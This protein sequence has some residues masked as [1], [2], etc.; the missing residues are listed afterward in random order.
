[1]QVSLAEPGI[2]LSVASSK[3]RPPAGRVSC[4]RKESGAVGGH[5]GCRVILGADHGK[6]P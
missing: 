3:Y 5:R 2:G 6:I 1:M 4:D